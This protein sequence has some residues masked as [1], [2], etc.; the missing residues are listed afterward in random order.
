MQNDELAE[1]AITLKDTRTLYKLI[2][3]NDF[4]D[5]VLTNEIDK[6]VIKRKFNNNETFENIGKA[7]GLSKTQTSRVYA[8]AIR[9]IKQQIRRFIHFYI[10]T[11]SGNFNPKK[12]VINDDTLIKFNVQKTSH[13]NIKDILIQD[14]LGSNIRLVT[15]LNNNGIYSIGNLTQ[16]SKKELFL[17]PNISLNRIQE[18]EC[19]LNHYNLK[20]S[21]KK[22]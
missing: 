2:G 11:K 20:L 9:R 10:E 19:L 12:T 1:K 16:Y 14:I 3:Q 17:M 6:I 7:I 18:I 21:A 5:L 22:Y 4:I 15:I 8:N 13:S